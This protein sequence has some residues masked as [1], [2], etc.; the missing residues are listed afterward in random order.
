M[1]AEIHGAFGYLP[2]QFLH[3]GS[4]KRTDKYGGSIENRSRFVL[5]VVDAVSRVAGNDRVGIK[6][7]PSNTFNSMS[8]SNRLALYTHLAEQLSQ[9]GLAYVTV[10]EA[11]EM[12]IKNG[13]AN[14]KPIPATYFKEILSKGGV[15]LVVNNGFNKEKATKVIESGQADA[16]SFGHDFIA[17]PDLVSRLRHDKPLAQVQWQYAYA[18]PDEASKHVGYTDYPTATD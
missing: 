1:H 10:M 2:N 6:L 5:E 18:Y 4:N 13:G 15:P 17:N 8:D 12:D 16:V 14:Y 3:D 7:S 11:G 9:R